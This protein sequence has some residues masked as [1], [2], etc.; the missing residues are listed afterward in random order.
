MPLWLA[1]HGQT[2]VNGLRDESGWANSGR[3]DELNQLTELGRRQA[4][5]LADA[6][7]QAMRAELSG[8]QRFVVCTSALSRA[9]ETATPFIERLHQ[10]GHAPEVRSFASLDEIDLGEWSNRRPSDLAPVERERLD[11]FRFGADASLRAPGGESFLDLLERTACALDALNATHAND[12]VVVFTHATTI[13]AMRMHAR[14]PL[15][16]DESGIL[17]WTGKAIGSA[18]YLRFDPASGRYLKPT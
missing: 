3:D 1:R 5:V 6:L 8:A 11:R 13:S 17:R 4:D 12:T 16:E 14:E 7:F 2:H 18:D 9:R 15:F 10:H